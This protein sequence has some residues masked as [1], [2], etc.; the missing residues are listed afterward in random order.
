MGTDQSII[1]VRDIVPR[2]RHPKIFAT[3]EALTPGQ[4]FQLVNDHDPKPLRYQFEAEMPDR[5]T[6][7]YL[8]EGPEAWRVRIGRR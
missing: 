8:E 3:F 4:S 7:E 1:D 2:E 5:F 6:W